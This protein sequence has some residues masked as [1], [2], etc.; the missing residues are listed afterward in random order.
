MPIRWAIL[1]LMVAFLQGSL[2]GCAPAASPTLTSRLYSTKLL[3][4]IPSGC[5]VGDVSSDTQWIAMVCDARYLTV[6]KIRDTQSI[7]L[8]GNASKSAYYDFAFSPDSTKLIV[9]VLDGGPIWLFTVGQWSTPRMLTSG[10]HSLLGDHPSWSPDGRTIAISHFKAGWALSMVD[11]LGNSQDLLRNNEVQTGNTYSP[12]NWFG[13]TWSPDSRELAYVTMGDPFHPQPVQLWILDIAS[14]EKKLMYAGKPEEA[15]LYDP[16]WSPGGTKIALYTSFTKPSSLYIYD[17]NKGTMSL[18]GN[19]PTNN[20]QFKWSPDRTHI[21]VCATSS[22]L[23]KVSASSG[24]SEQTDIDC[25]RYL[26][27]V[28]KNT[29]LSTNDLDGNLYRISLP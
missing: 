4:A 25:G 1:V 29:I 22:W 20:A 24:Q 15:G 26:G 23:S 27:W 6:Q 5:N 19:L 3:A 8:L 7:T 12:E 17:L 14:G 13:P 21:A 16:A 11:A 10:T 28:D 2:A 9:D 18:I